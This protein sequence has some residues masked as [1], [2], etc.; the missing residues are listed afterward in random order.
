VEHGCDVKQLRIEDQALAL[1]G[2]RAPEVDANGMRKQQLAFSVTNELRNFTCH[3]TVRN[4]Y[5]E[6]IA[7]CHGF[8]LIYPA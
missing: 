8:I 2:Q 7:H 1:P 4:F 5:A 6:D 3:F